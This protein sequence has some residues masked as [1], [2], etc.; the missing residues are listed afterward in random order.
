VT[1]NRA[2]NC[3]RR[4]GVVCNQVHGAQTKPALDRLCGAYAAKHVPSVTYGPRVCHVGSA[5]MQRRDVVHQPLPRRTRRPP[6]QSR[7]GSPGAI[8]RTAEDHA[9][10][11]CR[12]LCW[13]ARIDFNNYGVYGSTRR[14]PLISCITRSA[15]RS[16]KSSSAAK[17]GK[18]SRFG[19]NKIVGAKNRGRST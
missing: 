13:A 17:P 8:N 14:H 10:K 2:I 1:R 4:Y 12:V 18:P 7:L 16:N 11:Q 3:T 19:S 9:A 5:A 6:N 15:D